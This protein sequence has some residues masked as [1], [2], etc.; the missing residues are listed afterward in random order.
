MFRCK[1]SGGTERVSGETTA[2]Q[3]LTPE[4]VSERMSEAYA[5]RLLDALNPNPGRQGA[6]YGAAGRQIATDASITANAGSLSLFN[7]EFR[8]NRSLSGV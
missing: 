2:I 5:I 8:T 4:E 3:W 7:G 6:R 1:P